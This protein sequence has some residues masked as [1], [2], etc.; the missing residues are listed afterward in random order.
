MRAFFL[1]LIIPILLGLGACSSAESEVSAPEVAAVKSGGEYSLR[2][3]NPFEWSNEDIKR[4]DGGNF[5]GGK[6]SEY[7]QKKMASYGK[8]RKAPGYFSRDYH[9]KAWNGS[10]DY[11]VG[12]FQ[13]GESY[14]ESEKRS[15]FGGKKSHADGLAARERGKS[16]QTGNYRAGSANETG[17]MV[18]VPSSGY[19]ESRRSV[20]RKPLL[21]IE[22]DEYRQLSVDQSRSLLGKG[23]RED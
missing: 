14:R 8:D 19:V 20:K 17:Q 10:K 6:R 13:G 18:R 4:D 23:L 5:A 12:S 21:V 7:D 15:W 3:N 11:S 9:S 2:Q 1:L 22:E 16:F